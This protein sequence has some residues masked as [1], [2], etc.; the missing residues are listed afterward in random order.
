MR[1]TEAARAALADGFNRC[2]SL[3]VCLCLQ[4]ILSVPLCVSLRCGFE[5][6]IATVQRPNLPSAGVAK[7]L[8][9][10]QLEEEQEGVGGPES[11]LL[12]FALTREEWA[13]AAA[14]L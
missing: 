8:G 7:K 3:C 6:V 13:G 9:M 1:P 11:E 5:R 14:R 2:V 4:L 10:S 12:V